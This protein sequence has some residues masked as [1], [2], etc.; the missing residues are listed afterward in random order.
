[1]KLNKFG[2]LYINHAK[3]MT[4]GEISVISFISQVCSGNLKKYEENP[5]IP[6]KFNRIPTAKFMKRCRMSRRCV[7]EA[8]EKLIKKGLIYKVN[9]RGK[10]F[11]FTSE[12]YENTDGYYGMVQEDFMRELTRNEKLVYGYLSTLQQGR[13][14]CFALRE[15]IMRETGLGNLQLVTNAIT[16]LVKKGVINRQT[17]IYQCN[18]FTVKRIVSEKVSSAEI[19]MGRSAEID[20]GKSAEIDMGRSAEIDMA[21]N[22]NLFKDNSLKD[23]CVEDNP[24]SGETVHT[25]F[26]EKNLKDEKEGEKDNIHS[27][28]S[29]FHPAHISVSKESVPQYRNLSMTYINAVKV[30]NVINSFSPAEVSHLK[31]EGVSGEEFARVKIAIETKNAG[32]I[33]RPL[34]VKKIN[35]NEIKSLQNFA[36]KYSDSGDRELKYMSQDAREFI[37]FGFTASFKKRRELESLLDGIEKMNNVVNYDFGFKNKKDGNN[38]GKKVW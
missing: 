11:Y 1:M 5:S 3:N 21:Y 18:T 10:A 22:D 16:G 26:F 8:I 31:K 14:E 17:N 34:D 37:K 15:T 32:L 20:M 29:V 6:P 30:K 23:N 27:L 19:D 13:T 35:E 33:V 7:F 25:S 12:K 38:N 24:A 4:S 2:K 9:V 28:A 36:D